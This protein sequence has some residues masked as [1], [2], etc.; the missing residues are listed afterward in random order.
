MPGSGE[1]IK[2]I[3]ELERALKPFAD[4]ASAVE[5]TDKRDGD[6]V[7]RQQRPDGELCT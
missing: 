4:I 3:R 6:V 1:H 5:H 2:R 7:H